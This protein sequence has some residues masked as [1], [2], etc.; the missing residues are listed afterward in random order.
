M[1]KTLRTSGDYTIKAGAGS[2]GSNTIRL[3]AAQ[4]RIPGNLAI[5]G[6]QTVINSTTLTIEDQFLEVNRNNSTAGTED[7]GIFFNQGSSNHALLYYDAGNGEFQVG[8][9]TQDATANSISNITLGQLKVATIPTDANHAASKDYVDN[10]IVGGGFT[11]GFRG[12]DSA[13]V[14]VNTGNSVLVA[15]GSNI[16]TAATEQDTITVSLDRD[17]NG[18]DSVSTDRSNQDLTLTANGTGEIVIDPVLTFTVGTANPTATT[19]TKV[20]NKTAGGGGTGLYFKNSNINSGT[21]GEL[22]SK[23]KATALAIALG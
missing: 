6:T 21:E 4:V 22:I 18:I 8:T 16:S 19:S 9:T 11:I 5:D 3:D 20:Y 12:D 15:G 2:A 23:S 17:L 13:V 7:S 14:S 10:Q 1:A